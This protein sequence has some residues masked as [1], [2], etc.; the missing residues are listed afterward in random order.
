[1]RVVMLLSNSYKPDPRV[2][3]EAHAL[4]QDGQRVTV[5]C[6]DRQGELPERENDQ[7]VEIVRVHNIRSAYGSGWR[8]LFYLPRFWNQAAR[9]AI[10]LRPNVIH[11]HD[12]DTLSVGWRIKRRLRCRLVY[13]AHENYP[14]VM[15]LYLPP[16]M[17]KL[18]ETWQ[19]HLMP[20]ADAIITASTVLQ[21]EF[22]ARG[23]SPVTAL[24]NYHDLSAYSAVTD[25]EVHELRAELE[26]RPDQLLVA[27]LGGFSQD[28]ALLPL[29]ESAAYLPEAQVFLWGDGL[30]RA[31]VEAAVAQQP[32]VHYRGWLASAQLPR[33][34]RA[35]DVI[36]YG[37]RADYPGAIYN[38]PNTLAQAMA[39]G[40]PIVANDVGDLGRMIRSTQ[41]GVLIR[42]T[43]PQAIAQAIETL[44]DPALR[45]RLGANGLQA[46]Q[47]TYN[48]RI[49]E[50]QLVH[51]YR[52]L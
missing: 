6:W 52:A 37:L 29:I 50:N 15:S 19:N 26:V 49:V 51:L 7:G 24:G 12:L 5:I 22:R 36:Y 17:I 2:A 33:H 21:D 13:D 25:C 14:A 44:R 18:L 28:R 10:A 31:A 41:C 39:A 47:S 30:Q 16:L 48:A 11:C 9:V 23:L 20:H 32:N 38:A 8:Q 43:T 42:E 35:A 45:A 3:R 40:R 46:A 34:F 1:M 27:Y 4:A